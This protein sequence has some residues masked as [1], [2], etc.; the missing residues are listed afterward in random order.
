M[1]KN[2]IRILA[3][4]A[5][6]GYEF[7]TNA[8]VVYYTIGGTADLQ[9]FNVSFLNSSYNVYAG[10]IQISQPDTIP[11]PNNSS[12]PQSYVTVCTDFKGSLYIGST[13]AYNAPANGFAGQ[14]G[15]DPSWNNPALAIENAAYLFYHDGNPTLTGGITGNVQTMAALQ[16]AVWMVLYDTTSSGNVVVNSSSEFNVTTANNGGGDTAA[17]TE[18]L[19]WISAL[20]GQYGYTGSLLTPVSTLGNQGNPDNQLPQEL[21]IAAGNQSQGAPVPEPSTMLAGALLLLPCG[22]GVI[23]I[24]R[25]PRQTPVS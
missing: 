9:T 13:Y 16:L 18:A 17:I 11:D 10:G 4:T 14:L 12:M 15:I 3:L 21:M 5:L 20:N 8:G 7:N 6:V 22:L 23:R 1:N 24:L 25:N 19:G 2:L